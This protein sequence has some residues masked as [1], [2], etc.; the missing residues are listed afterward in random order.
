MAGTG[1][2]AKVTESV[3]KA[4]KILSEGGATI[5]EI[6]EY[7]KLGECTVTYIRRAETFEEY[8]QIIAALHAKWRQK[9]AAEK[10]AKEAPKEEPKEPPKEEPKEAPKEEP[11]VVEHRQSITIQATHFMMQELQKTNELLTGISAKLAFIVDEL[12]R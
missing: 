12:T 8:K 6:S 4:V 10:A 9:K 5:K 3:F 7:M 1:R 2:T 11:K